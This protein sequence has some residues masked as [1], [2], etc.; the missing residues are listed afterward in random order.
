[1]ARAS[2]AGRHVL[3]VQFEVFEMRH[4]FVAAAPCQLAAAVF[5]AAATALA[6]PAAAQSPEVRR[7]PFPAQAPGATHTIRIIPEACAYLHGGFTSDAAA[8]YR[9]TASRTGKRCQ[10]RARLVDAAKAAPSTASGWVL[11]DLIRIPNAAC[12]TQ[13]A[14]IRIWRKP[15]D[16]AP[17]PTDAQGRQRIY[18]GDAKRDAAAGRIAA[19]GAYAAT[20][21][22]EGKGCR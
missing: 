16:N 19:I 13:E 2:S 1:M 15:V 9:Y 22:M 5:L 14:V 3:F 6:G 18:L 10:P 17:P 8:P 11:N 4:S 12:A 7:A 21:E 20:L